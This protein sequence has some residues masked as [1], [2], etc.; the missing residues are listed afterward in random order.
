MTV[1]LKNVSKSFGDRPVL[2]NV[3]LTLE[4]G[5]PLCVTGP[6]GCGKTTL[7][8]IVLGLE[9][10]DSGTVLYSSGPKPRFGAMFQEDRLFETL[11]AV[12]NLRLA[13]GERDRGK[14]R[15]ALLHLLPED[16]LERPVSALSGGQRRR[17]AL[18]RALY[19]AREEGL[20]VRENISIGQGFRDK[21]IPG[22][23]IGRCCTGADRCAKGCPPTAGEILRLL[24]E[25]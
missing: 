4:P 3:S 13:A 17:A 6:S 5:R 16:A 10:P 9:K 24:R 23:G 22:L 20:T 21:S 11:D 12:E 19:Q 14:L 25:E 18:V 8:R 2:E 15:K 7:L 1:T